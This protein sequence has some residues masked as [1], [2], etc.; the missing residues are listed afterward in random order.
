MYSNNYYHYLIAD[1][2]NDEQ[3]RNSK[4]FVWSVQVLSFHAIFASFKIK[5]FHVVS[6]SFKLT[7]CFKYH[8]FDANPIILCYIDCLF[9]SIEILQ[10]VDGCCHSLEMNRSISS[11]LLWRLLLLRANSLQRT[12]QLKRNN[13]QFKIHKTNTDI[14]KY[15]YKKILNK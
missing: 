12:I 11:I 14:S 6:A 15:T 9:W 3:L 8:F 10:E 4:V 5:S 13:I 1:T 7:C 2:P